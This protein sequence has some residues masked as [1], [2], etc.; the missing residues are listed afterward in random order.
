MAH[1]ESKEILKRLKNNQGLKILLE[2]C[3]QTFQCQKIKT[4]KQLEF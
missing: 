3:L 4:G 2:N 1:F